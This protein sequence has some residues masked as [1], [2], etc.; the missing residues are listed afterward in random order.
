MRDE[1]ERVE[2]IEKY[3]EGAMRGTELKT[4]EGKISVDESFAEEVEFQRILMERTAVLATKRAVEEASD[5][6]SKTNTWNDIRLKL[7]AMGI[8]VICFVS[9]AYYF[10]I[11]HGLSSAN[12]P[13]IAKL[14][15]TEQ[16]DIVTSKTEFAYTDTTLLIP[17]LPHAIKTKDTITTRPETASK[18][19]KRIKRPET[20]L[21]I[22][23]E[24]VDI[25]GGLLEI[26]K[27]RSV[28]IKTFQLSKHEITQ[29]QW[30][31]VMGK[32]PSYF[33][34]CD[35]CPVENVSWD[36]IQL[37]L[38]KLNQRNNSNYRLPTHPEWSFTARG[39][40]IRKGL[41]HLKDQASIKKIA[42]CVENA[43]YRTH[44]VGQKDANELGIY[45]LNG[46]VWEWVGDVWPDDYNADIKSRHRRS[47]DKS[48]KILLG[49][50]Y[51]ISSRDFYLV[52]YLPQFSL[53]N[54]SSPNL[55]FRLARSIE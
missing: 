34:G 13:L 55:G 28:D 2:E 40:T 49:G 42:W 12:E 24:M 30:R 36:D 43:Q 15:S 19:A 17:D 53:P 48:D 7:G 33:Q 11:D 52:W 18:K 6:F 38:A 31:E 51:G 41:R 45:D 8:A 32:N 47:K 9:I 46:N 39:G 50:S 10:N 1:L 23:I 29:Q 16:K 54:V 5:R 26:N 3:L 37:F 35:Q 21:P 14:D 20:V 27:N 22:T 44:E 4:F 25:E